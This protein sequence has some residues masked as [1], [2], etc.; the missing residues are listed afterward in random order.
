MGDFNRQFHSASYLPLINLIRNQLKKA[1]KKS[2]TV[3]VGKIN[4]AKLANFMEIECWV[5][6]ACNEGMVD[7]FLMLS[8]PNRFD[9][10]RRVTEEV[11]LE[12]EV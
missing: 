5:W 9:C 12:L 11:V 6:V 8:P 10:G 3:S 2:Y 7:S 4:P 1:H